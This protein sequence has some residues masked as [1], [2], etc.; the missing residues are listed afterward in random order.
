M[1]RNKPNIWQLLAVVGML[2][3]TSGVAN[4]QLVPRTSGKC[5]AY[6]TDKGRPNLPNC[7]DKTLYARCQEAA[8]KKNIP[9]RK[10]REFMK[11]CAKL[12]EPKYEPQRGP[13][14]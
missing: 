12:P 6:F 5:G 8:V 4:A 3:G 7:A 10:L 9:Q 13:R 11:R 2:A 14:R 1:N